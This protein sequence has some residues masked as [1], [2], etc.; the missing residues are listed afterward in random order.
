M[1][2]AA[3]DTSRLFFKARIRVSIVDRERQTE[4]SDTT[5]KKSNPDRRAR[6]SSPVT[7]AADRLPR[8][9]CVLWHPPQGGAVT[10]AGLGT[11]SHA[12][13]SPGDSSAPALRLRGQACRPAAS[14][15]A[16]G[17]GGRVP[18]ERGLH[19]ATAWHQREFVSDLSLQGSEASLC[20]SLR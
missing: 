20:V 6:P 8:G 11:T 5:R 7:D 18:S 14:L 19:G 15:E 9:L 16:R 10:P 13:A 3:S 1:R 17:R 12:H 2:D 4:S